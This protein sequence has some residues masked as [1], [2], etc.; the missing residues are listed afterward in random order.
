MVSLEA[1]KGL[2]PSLQQMLGSEDDLLFRKP[3]L[4]ALSVHG[5]RRLKFKFPV[6]RNREADER[7]VLKHSHQPR[8]SQNVVNHLPTPILEAFSHALWQSLFKKN[9]NSDRQ[10][11]HVVANRVLNLFLLAEEKQQFQL[12]FW[13]AEDVKMLGLTDS[14]RLHSNYY[15]DERL[16]S[17]SLSAILS[18]H[19][20][21]YS[22][23]NPKN[24]ADKNNQCFLKYL[25]ARTLTYG[26]PWA[27]F[28]DHQLPSQ[29]WEFS[30]LHHLN[31]V[32]HYLAD[33]SVYQRF[34]D[35][36]QKMPPLDML[37]D[38]FGFLE[39]LLKER[40]YGSKIGNSET[41]RPT[42]HLVIV[43]GITEER[44]LPQFAHVLG[45]DL[46]QMGVR[47][48]AAGGKNQVVQLYQQYSP[49]LSIPIM[50]ILDEDAEHVAERIQTA[51]RSK[52]RLV[53][54]AEGEIEDT[55][56]LPLVLKTINRFYEPVLPL[57]EADYNQII[58]EC[59]LETRRVDVLKVLWRHYEL[60]DGTFDKIHFADCLAQMLESPD[61][62]PEE[63]RKILC[64]LES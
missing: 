20:F 29:P 50:L 28:L 55:Y 49:C 22:V 61:D 35:L 7:F 11:D 62:I 21:H 44:L 2:S 41:L 19:H 64:Y 25:I 12:P 24:R 54:L 47:V 40:K 38:C 51:L 5:N 60:G 17:D 6:I 14:T 16:D 63:F 1:P 9:D 45:L 39:T 10:D 18:A 27:D 58:Q 42:N 26:L 48:V 15:R 3:T 56:P 23:L 34:S 8:L 33:E 57:Q 59:P 36:A 13:V 32:H 30:L 4:E 53:I 31:Q 43:E 46:A 52:D 37:L